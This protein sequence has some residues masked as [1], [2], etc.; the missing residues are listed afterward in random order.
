M[1]RGSGARADSAGSPCLLP[2]CLPVIPSH[3]IFLRFTTLPV[4]LPKTPSALCQALGLRIRKHWGKYTCFQI[5]RVFSVC[6]MLSQVSR[7]I[8]LLVRMASARTLRGHPCPHQAPRGCRVARPWKKG[9]RNLLLLYLQIWCLD[10]SVRHI[11][12]LRAMVY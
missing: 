4:D 6:K 8:L 5:F 10:K 11:N 12:G 1:L 3:A 2:A 9:R 7:C